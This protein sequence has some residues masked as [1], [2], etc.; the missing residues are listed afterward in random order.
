[1]S[2]TSKFTVELFASICDKI[3]QGIT[4]SEICRG[5][6]M[7]SRQ[8]V[9]DWMKDNEDLSLRFARARDVGFDAIAEETLD[10]ADDSRNDWIQRNIGDEEN[11]I[12]IEQVNTEHIQR[13]KLRIET[14]LKLL[15]KWDPRRYGEKLDLTSKGE[16]MP[17]S[18]QVS[19]V[20]PP[21]ET[22]DE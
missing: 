2:T 7:P 18:F 15:A 16:A 19:I 20:A 10:I 21:D 9:Y 13:S 11:P 5:E 12:L 6:G 4:L 22:D 8:A 17:A 14:R 3:S 1:M